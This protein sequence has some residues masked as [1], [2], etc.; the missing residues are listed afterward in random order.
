MEATEQV[1]FNRDDFIA[2]DW[3]QVVSAETIHGYASI[4]QAFGRSSNLYMED[5]ESSKGYMMK[6]LS[7]ACSMMF[8]VKSI[9]EPFKPIFQDFQEGTRSAIPE[10]LTVDELCFFEGILSEVDDIWLKA[11]IADLLWLCRKPKLPD[12][13]RIAIN[14]YRSHAINAKTWKQD[15]GNCWERACRLCLQIKD[16]ATLEL[17]EKELY[18]AFL[19]NYADSPFMVLWLAQMLDNLGLAKDKHAEIAQRLFII[20]QKMHESNEFD[21]ARFYLEL[22]VKKYQQDKDEQGW[23]DSLI[24]IAKSHELEADQRSAE[25]MMI[26]NGCY[27]KAIQ[28]Y[29]R[30]P[31]KNRIA[32]DVDNRVQSL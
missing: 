4:S 32:Y 18:S 28:G 21:N 24:M 15:V 1:K 29:R 6:L 19:I 3:R 8:E 14:A 13:A 27:E 17:I 20:A 23:L 2:S 12:H 16:F 9:N 30:I 11:R 26:A 31:V 10:D 22:A 5:G 7:K 25:S